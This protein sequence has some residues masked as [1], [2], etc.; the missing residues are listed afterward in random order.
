MRVYALV[1][2]NGN[3]RRTLHWLKTMEHYK[4]VLIIEVIDDRLVVS[5]DRIGPRCELHDRAEAEVLIKDR[6]ETVKFAL[7]GGTI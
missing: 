7:N 5:K 2:S 6:A 3:V 1:D 4:A